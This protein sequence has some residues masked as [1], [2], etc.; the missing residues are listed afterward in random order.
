MRRDPRLVAVLVV[1]VVIGVTWVAAA[2]EPTPAGSVAAKSSVIALRQTTL[3][4]PQAGG[5]P[6]DGAARIAY[7]DAEATASTSSS[8]SAGALGPDGSPTPIPLDAGGAWVVDGPSSLGPMQVNATGPVAPSLSAVQFTRAPVGPAAQISAVQCEGATTDAW[9]AGFSSQ[10]GAHAA[11]FLSN[12]D[13][14]PASV[15]VSIWG[16]QAGE[17]NIRRGIA[18]DA[19]SQVEVSLDQIEPGLSVGVVHVVATAGRVVPAV[20]YDAENGSIPLG[21]DWVPPTSAPA[22]VQTVPGIL[23]DAGS[24]RLVV[25]DPGPL[26]ATFSLAVVTS[27]GSFEPTEF[28]S[29]Q[30]AAGGVSDITLDPVLQTE[31]AAVIVTSTQPVVVGAV[32]AL[33]LDATGAS[34]FAFT[35]AAAPLSGPTVLAGGEVAVL[36][37]TELL[38]SATGADAQVVVSILPTDPGSIRADNPITVAGGTTTVLD[39]ATLTSDPAPGVVVTPA[40][41][42][43]VYAAWSLAEMSVGSNGATSAVTNAASGAAPPADVGTGAITELVL[44]TPVRSLVRPPARFDPAVGVR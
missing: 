43:P 20:R 15:D 36:R 1:G 9:F 22:K 5:A 23:G 34:D 41:G 18:V 27:D 13:A 26:D 31:A 16:A 14:V 7:A 30:V 33:P 4:C 35:A 38:L 12:V 24:R 32:S 42:G 10:V 39:L 25:A 2:K 28:A 3:A 29:L 17:P 11:L 6:V 37:R 19:L 44:A 40:G 21:V 8:L